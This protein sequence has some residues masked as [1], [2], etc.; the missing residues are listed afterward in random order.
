MTTTQIENAV[1]LFCAIATRGEMEV[2]ACV[3]YNIISTTSVYWRASM[4]GR[5]DAC[6][7]TVVAVCDVV[8]KSPGDALVNAYNGYVVKLDAYLAEQ[9]GEV[10][11]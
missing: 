4:F 9:A 1:H 10:T 5:M 6:G 3:E 11:E 2:T 8:G 7:D